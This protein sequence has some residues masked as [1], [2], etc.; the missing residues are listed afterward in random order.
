MLQFLVAGGDDLASDLTAAAVKEGKT[1]AELWAL[2]VV[3]LR[4]AYFKV[5]GPD[6]VGVDQLTDL[7][8][9]NATAAQPYFP[10][11]FLPEN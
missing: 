11:W 7:A 10:W 1:P 2:P 4:A 6:E 3:H 5:P 8:R 9:R